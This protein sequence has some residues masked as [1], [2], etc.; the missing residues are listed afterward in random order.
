L[1]KELI[2]EKKEKGAEQISPKL[3]KRLVLR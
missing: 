2:D 3:I 1:P